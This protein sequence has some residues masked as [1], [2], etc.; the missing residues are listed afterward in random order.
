MAVDFVSH[1]V[2][3]EGDWYHT[4]EPLEFISGGH[5]Q[6]LSKRQL[7]RVPLNKKGPLLM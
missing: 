5:G 2:T 3:K 6:S 4:K 1:C 7:C